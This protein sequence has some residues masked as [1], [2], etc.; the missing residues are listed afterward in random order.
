MYTEKIFY[1]YFRSGNTSKKVKL[2]PPFLWMDMITAV[3]D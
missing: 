1:S 2:N 3:L